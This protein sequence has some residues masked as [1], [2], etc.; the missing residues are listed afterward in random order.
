MHKFNVV[1]FMNKD[2][3]EYWDMLRMSYLSLKATNQHAYP[4]LQLPVTINVPAAIRTRYL[5]LAIWPFNPGSKYLDFPYAKQRAYLN[6][7][8][9]NNLSLDAYI[10]C[11]IDTLFMKDAREPFITSQAE[12]MPT[13]RWPNSHDPKLAYNFGVTYSR[14][15]EFWRKVYDGYATRQ[16]ALEGELVPN[17]LLNNMPQDSMHPLPGYKYNHIV[18]RSASADSYKEATI[19]HFKG[20][21]KPYMQHVFDRHFFID[22]YGVAH[23]K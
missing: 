23:M 18:E 8:I 10:F 7:I 4:I 1:Y 17:A 5:D 12:L 20:S 15:T 16:L 11:D 19:L 22:D 14:R 3:P 21:R 2:L 13:T 6:D 9:V